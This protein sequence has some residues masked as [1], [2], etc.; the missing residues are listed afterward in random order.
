MREGKDRASW[1]A[2]GLAV[3]LVL[4]AVVGIVERDDFE[5]LHE[6]HFALT[7]AQSV[8]LAVDVSPGV[9][10]AQLVEEAIDARLRITEPDLQAESTLRRSGRQSLLLSVAQPTQLQIEIVGRDVRQ[11]QGH[12][13]LTL[14]RLSDDPARETTHIRA[15][16]LLSA[17]YANVA[18]GTPDALRSADA[19]LQA[20]A[21]ML[22][23]DWEQESHRAM[24]ELARLRYVHFDDW[25]GAAATAESVSVWGR[26]NDD[27]ILAARADAVHAAA[28]MERAQSAA[29]APNLHAKAGSL[30][31]RACEVFHQHSLPLDLAECV[32]NRGLLDD[33]RSRYDAAS[34]AYARAARLFQQAGDSFGEAKATQNMATVEYLSGHLSAAI[35]NYSKV[36]P[37]LDVEVQ[38]D[39]YAAVVNNLA[40]ASAVRGDF[41]RALDL[42]SESLAIYERLG[43]EVDVAKALYGLGATYYLAGD[44]ERA[45]PFFERALPISRA[46]D[47]ARVVR[48]NLQ[49][50]GNALADLGRYQEALQR[51]HESLQFAT[52]PTALASGVLAIAQIEARL[53]ETKSAKDRLQ[54][55][56]AVVSDPIVR[57]RIFGELARLDLMA[58]RLS[59]AIEQATFAARTL[60]HFELGAAASDAYA[61]VAEA[62]LRSDRPSDALAS[63]E[64][65]LRLGGER[66][67][68]IWSP[69]LRA[70]QAASQR[71]VHDLQLAALV[72]EG[73]SEAL[74]W[75]NFRVA[76]TFK[77]QGLL[78]WRTTL[79]ST[80]SEA[81]SEQAEAELR[82]SELQLRVEAVAANTGAADKRVVALLDEISRLRLRLDTVPF[83]KGDANRE[84]SEPSDESYGKQLRSLLPADAVV[85]AY[86]LGNPHSYA[87]VI[88]AERIEQ[89]RLPARDRIAKVIQP[90]LANLHEPSRR[91]TSCGASVAKLILAPLLPRLR[92]ERL[93]IVPDAELNDVPFAALPTASDGRCD[94]PMID[95]FTVSYLPSIRFALHAARDAAKGRST[96]HIAIVADTVTVD[97]SNGRATLPATRDEASSIESSLATWQRVVLTGREA[98]R[99]QLLALPFDQLSVLHLATHAQVRA[100]TPELSALYLSGVNAANQAVPSQVTV[101]DIRRHAV[102][103]DLVVLSACETSLGKVVVGEGA[104]G[105]TH[106]FLSAGANAVIATDRRVADRTTAELMRDFYAALGSGKDPAAALTI[107]QRQA[108]SRPQPQHSSQDWAAFRLV[109]AGN[110]HSSLQ[111]QQGDGS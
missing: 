98:T 53:G 45:L 18:L 40:S 59:G 3:A 36:L 54:G 99:A 21:S 61:T 4:G 56:L 65:A 31:E 20:A 49:A 71:R 10:R 27:A 30:L 51:Q 55:Q 73:D 24:L 62:Q 87:W 82:L 85:V 9:Y 42:H 39:L 63:L 68:K 50:T 89:I 69:D 100:A 1:K 44:P 34:A 16:R 13:V 111:Q 37:L 8:N 105:L 90:W 47:N 5:R 66:N 43:R 52:T 33:Y 29:E 11:K 32:N 75:R 94:A 77:A 79:A 97:G 15:E 104:I 86:H 92:G 67:R 88:D 96:K 107:A 74:R 6:Q 106:A 76:D 64:H 81:M 23:R 58:G 110:F 41:Q 80:P 57:A 93:W 17:A 22:A 102:R 46:R 25:N 109:G 7:G 72:R 48:S 83:R 60:E 70:S 2:R 103:A 12:V 91:E 19:E 84:A 14:D 108:R 35:D 38:T 26:A 28:L 101:A 95:R 78:E